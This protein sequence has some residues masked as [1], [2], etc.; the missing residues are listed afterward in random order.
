MGDLHIYQVSGMEDYLPKIS[1]YGNRGY[2][3]RFL[4]GFS[5]ALFPKVEMEILDNKKNNIWLKIFNETR[6][7]TLL[8]KKHDL[9]I[10]KM[11][12]YVRKI[13]TDIVKDYICEG[14]LC[15][16]E[17]ERH[18]IYNDD[19]TSEV[20]I[21]VS[22]RDDDNK[23]IKEYGSDEFNKFKDID[24]YLHR[25]YSDKILAYIFNLS[26]LYNFYIVGNS[27]EDLFCKTLGY[28]P[29]LKCAIHGKQCYGTGYI[30]WN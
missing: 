27:K 19:C 16:F 2:L 24:N 18:T 22:V 14:T 17:I 11:N 3:Q 1:Y 25:D 7:L 8:D 15:W 4:D 13:M 10:K 28:Y 29:D 6:K 12:W 5:A 21:R 9:I 23:F 30:D 20:K 26:E